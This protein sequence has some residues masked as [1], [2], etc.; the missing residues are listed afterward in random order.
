M[1]RLDP[2]TRATV[3]SCLC[4]GMAVRAIV[5]ATGV[6]KN[7]IQKLIAD[8]GAACVRF[9]DERVRGLRCERIEADELHAFIGARQ[10]NVRSAKA[11]QWGDIW[12]WSTLCATTKIVP[13]WMLGPR[14][15]I[16]AITLIGDLCPRLANPV[17]LNTDGLR[18]YQYAIAADH[19]HKIASYA[20]V[21]KHFDT[22]NG[23]WNDK[24]NRY[25]QPAVTAVT[26]EAVFGN[27]DVAHASTSYAERLNL[28]LR[29]HNRK[30]S[31]LTNAHAK[32]LRM[33]NFSMAIGYC[34]YNWCRPHETLSGRTPAM[35]QG[36]T[37]R[38]WAV[39]DL[40]ELPPCAN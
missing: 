4:E 16:S 35:V 17:E 25:Q 18:A 15:G 1:N 31:R 22:P 8:V 14:D 32:K 20:R 13:S 33:L 3:V 27:P 40:L 21:I 6:A 10:K 19:D 11:G 38:R 29:Q 36:L 5:R 7:T 24:H 23:R 30:I 37:D 9:H 28:G 26:K 12:L 34:Y 39:S 2:K